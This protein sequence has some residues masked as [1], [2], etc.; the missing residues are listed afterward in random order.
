M[1]DVLA[2]SRRFYLRCVGGLPA[3]SCVHPRRYA[4]EPWSGHYEVRSPIWTS[5][6]WCQVG[7]PSRRVR[8]ARAYSLRISL[9]VTWRAILVHGTWLDAAA[10]RLGDACWRRVI[11]DGGRAVEGG[12]DN[13]IG[14]AR[15][16]VPSLQRRNVE[17]PE[18]DARAGGRNAGGPVPC[19]GDHEHELLQLCGDHVASEWYVV[20]GWAMGAP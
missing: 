20:M 6:H 9:A 1:I 7:W 18:C 13:C 14:D 17:A 16:R 15:R 2:C 19:V 12:R 10:G 11:R 8:G 3:S 5:A 4:L